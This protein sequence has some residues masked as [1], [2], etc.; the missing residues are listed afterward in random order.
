MSTLSAPDRP[1]AP[2]VP[3]AIV[4]PRERPRSA[5][6]MARARELFPGGVN[7]P[8][9]AFG[10]V[11]GEP[12]VVAR[13]EGARIWDADGNEYL[14]YVLSWGPLV[15]GHAPR[16]VLDALARDDAARHELRHPDRAGGRA[17]ERDRARACRTSRCCASSRAAPR[18]R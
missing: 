11:G 10:G 2:T 7:S 18:P 12:F 17:G 9:R 3:D 13:G 15:L 4:P 6:I 8:V 14:D 16:V 1:T 5:A